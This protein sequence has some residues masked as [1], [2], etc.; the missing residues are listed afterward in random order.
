MEAIVGTAEI[1]DYFGSDL[2]RM[3]DFSA[4]A[5]AFRPR[6]CFSG[7]YFLVFFWQVCMRFLYQCEFPSCIFHMQRSELR[8]LDD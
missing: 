7:Q 6:F 2:R 8:R 5:A 1:I 3:C 4:R